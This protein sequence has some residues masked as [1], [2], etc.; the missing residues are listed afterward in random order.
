MTG[1]YASNFKFPGTLDDVFIA[2]GPAYDA[3]QG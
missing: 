1:V 3:H 2:A